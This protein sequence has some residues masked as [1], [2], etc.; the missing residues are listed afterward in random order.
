M[1]Y[2]REIEF[3]RKLAA[4][5]G[6]NA[7]RF[8][9][10]GVTAEAKP[11]ESPVTAADRDNERLMREAIEAAFPEDGIL[12]EEGT[13]KAGR[14]GR[15]WIIDPIDGTRDFV[16]G[17]RFWCVLIALEQDGEAVLGL[18]HFPMLGETCHASR[19]AGTWR[20]GRRVSVS[21][22]ARIGEAVISPDGLLSTASAPWSPRLLEFLASFWAVRSHGGA[23]DAVMFASG[24]LDVWAEPKA[25]TWDLAPLQ[26]IVEEA[27]GRYFALDGSRRTDAGSGIACTPALEADVRAFFG[28]PRR[29]GEGA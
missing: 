25:A 21:S 18:A 2:E 7:A 4:A 15:R 19:G 6:D 27:G 9:A 20:N 10:A 5:A 17:N 26:V 23:F 22:I 12:G 28:V 29:A 11:D 13:R 24:E 16:R 1:A 8:L 14:S 3:A